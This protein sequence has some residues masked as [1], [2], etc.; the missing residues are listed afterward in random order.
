M[1]EQQLAPARE[2]FWG[3]GGRGSGAYEALDWL[4]AVSL[5]W[6]K[7]WPQTSQGRLLV[8]YDVSSSYVEGRC[9]ELARF[10]YNATAKR[11]SCR[12]S[13]GFSAPRWLPVAIEVFEGNTGDPKPCRADRQTEAALKLDRVVLVSDR[14]MITDARIRE[15]LEPPGSMDHRLRAPA[16]QALAADD[17]RCRCRCRRAGYGRNQLA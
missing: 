6:R 1:D 2:R 4:F 11:A 17:G 9:C 14:G 13:T 16:I 12:S 7:G 3:S 5:K 8:L 10:G 15:E